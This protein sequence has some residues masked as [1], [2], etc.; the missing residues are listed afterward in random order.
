[1][2]VI[3]L[4]G[5]GGGRFFYDVLLKT[6]TLMYIHVFKFNLAKNGGLSPALTLNDSFFSTQILYGF[7]VSLRI[8]I[9]YFYS[10]GQLVLLI[11]KLNYV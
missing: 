9:D 10:I 2:N 11:E 4:S 8:R 7:C 1:M 6:A 5:G 3:G